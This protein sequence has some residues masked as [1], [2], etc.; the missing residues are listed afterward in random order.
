MIS[1]AGK[2]LLM[3]EDTQ[4]YKLLNNAV[5]MTDFVGRHVLYTYNV[6]TLKM[7]KAEAAAQAIEEFINFAPPTHEM[8][9]YLNRMGFLWFTKYGTRVLKTMKDNAVAKPFDVLM[10]L[11]QASAMGFDTIF[12]SIPGVTKGLLSNVGNPVSMFMSSLDE[13]LPFLGI[14]SVFKTLFSK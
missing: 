7:D 3:T 8:I 14:D 6:E 10:T 12:G 1:G 2:Q 13:S 4:V 11:G 9:D 5:K